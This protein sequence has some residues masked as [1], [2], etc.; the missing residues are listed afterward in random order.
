MRCLNCTD[1]ETRACETVITLEGDENTIIIEDVPAMVCD[2]CGEYFL[3][4]EV[5]AAVKILAERATGLG[6]GEHR[7]SFL[8]FAN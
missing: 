2:I 4:P 5:S 3:T 1:I 8:D 7:I 6:E